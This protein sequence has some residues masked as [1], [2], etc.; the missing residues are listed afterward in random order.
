MRRFFEAVVKPLLDLAAPARIVEIGAAEGANSALVAR[1]C[2]S[3]QARLDVI[4][5]APRFDP[6]A[7]EREHPAAKVHVGRSLDVLP[8]I[9]PPDVALIDGDH[10]WYTVYHELNALAGGAAAHGKPFPVCVFHDTAWPYGR[11]DVYYDPSAIPE[12]HRRPWR[13][14]AVVPNHPGIVEQGLNGHL[15]QAEQEGGPHNGVLT[16]IED[17]ISENPSGFHL[18]HLPVLFGLSL[19]L[20]RATDTLVPGLKRFVDDLELNPCWRAL[21]E[22]AEAERCHSLAFRGRGS[23][24]S[25]GGR[26]LLELQLFWTSSRGLNFRESDSCRIGTPASTARRTVR[27]KIP[28][29]LSRTAQFRIDLS[30]QP[31][32]ARIFGMRLL[33]AGGNTMWEWDGSCAAL[34]T[35]VRHDMEIFAVPDSTDVIVHFSSDDPRLS[36]PIP[37]GALDSF[38]LGGAFEVDFS[39]IG[40]IVPADASAWRSIGRRSLKYLSW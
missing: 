24:A 37:E 3:R 13:R 29:G 34:R 33:G 14:G 10:N 31:G 9:P 26:R 11:R 39:W 18:V 15:C 30:N 38:G 5:T 21:L 28:A 19:L 22:L 2:E 32:L 40:T 1:W 35:A 6:M 16:A 17:F 4:D 12:S 7:F 20:P 25:A 23:D 27:I 8:C 36:L